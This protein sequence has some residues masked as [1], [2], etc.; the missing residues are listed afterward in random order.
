MPGIGGHGS[1]LRRKY[2]VR[3]PPTCIRW[4]YGPETATT[5]GRQEGFEIDVRDMFIQV[6][7]ICSQQ[8]AGMVVKRILFL[9]VIRLQRSGCR[10]DSI[11]V[12][13]AIAVA[14]PYTYLL[15]GYGNSRSSYPNTLSCSTFQVHVA[16][17]HHHL[18]LSGPCPAYLLLFEYRTTATLVT[19]LHLRI[20]LIVVNMD[21][22]PPAFR[23]VK[24]LVAAEESSPLMAL[25]D[26][27]TWSDPRGYF[28][29]TG[30]ALD[31]RTS[32]LKRAWITLLRTT[33][34]TQAVSTTSRTRTKLISISSVSAYSSSSR[35]SVPSDTSFRRAG[36]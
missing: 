8:S 26:I 13:A 1:G 6:S 2:L 17:R 10:D 20:L 29:I 25:A 22:N 27:M 33:N 23:T 18:T 12:D 35:H 11:P 4:G 30:R 5:H 14:F 9:A 31:L 32:P 16:G 36:P 28:L 34:P 24:V 21:L 7:S 19:T 3:K 15:R